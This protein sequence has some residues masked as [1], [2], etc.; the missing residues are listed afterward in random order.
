MSTIW[1]FLGYGI[2]LALA[3]LLLYLF[4][5]RS[6]Y[7]HVLSLACALGL[8]LMPSPG[9][10]QGP[11]YDLTLGSL[12]LFLLVWGIGGLLMVQTRHEKHA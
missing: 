12:F 3:L 11:S 1:V 7:W 10:W 9:T 8:G 4:H 2:S 6:W 5:A